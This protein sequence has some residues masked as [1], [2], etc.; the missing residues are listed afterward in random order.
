MQRAQQDAVAEAMQRGCTHVYSL[1]ASEVC[2]PVRVVPS[3][4]PS[5]GAQQAAEQP[6]TL[7]GARKATIPLPTGTAGLVNRPFFKHRINHEM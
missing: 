3:E 4:Q 6:S 7:V 1:S 2:P 5:E